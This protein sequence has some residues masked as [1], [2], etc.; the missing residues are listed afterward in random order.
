M[1][2]IKRVNLEIK[3]TLKDVL[4]KVDKL[5]KVKVNHFVEEEYEVNVRFVDETKGMQIIMDSG[6]PVSIVSSKWIERYL[7]DIEVK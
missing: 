4:D 5:E 6:V 3:D 1:E 7:K 2:E